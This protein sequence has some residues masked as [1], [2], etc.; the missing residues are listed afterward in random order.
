[1]WREL[2]P[3][4]PDLSPCDYFLWGFLKIKIFLKM[5]QTVME[6]RSLIIQACNDITEDMFRRVINITVRVEGVARRNSGR[7]EH[8]VH[9]V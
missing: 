4:S 1:M 9:R 3:N 5:P 2:A 7:I 8:V 6:L